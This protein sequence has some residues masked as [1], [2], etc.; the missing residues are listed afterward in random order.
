MRQK[1]LC[2]HGTHL[3][4]PELFEYFLVTKS[5]ASPPVGGL[6]KGVACNKKNCGA[7]FFYLTNLLWINPRIP[8]V[9][10]INIIIRA[11]PRKTLSK[12]LIIKI[13]TRRAKIDIV[14]ILSSGQRR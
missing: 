13:P 2:F 8:P 1:V 4:P 14:K 11:V 7:S 10:D 3:C 12:P 9:S 5:I 6:K